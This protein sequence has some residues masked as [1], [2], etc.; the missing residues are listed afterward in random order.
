MSNAFNQIRSD[1]MQ[2]P[3]RQRAELASLLLQSLAES[4][5]EMPGAAWDAELAN[6]LEQIQRGAVTGET[7]DS[8]FHR[9]REKYS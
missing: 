8:V 5:D 3:E 2:L 9:I 4:T 7:A 1:A 6:R